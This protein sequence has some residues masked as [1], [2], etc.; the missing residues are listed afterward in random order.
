MTGQEDDNHL[1][2]TARPW[3]E[4]EKVSGWVSSHGATM[5]GLGCA[6]LE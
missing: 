1:A 2:A 4:M 3:Q 6:G 5:P